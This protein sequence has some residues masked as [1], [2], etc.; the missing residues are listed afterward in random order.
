MKSVGA[1]IEAFT[2]PLPNVNLNLGAVW[3]NTKYRDNLVG[4]NGRPL[5]NALF[6]LPGRRISNSSAWTVTGVVSIACSKAGLAP[7]AMNW[8]DGKTASSA[9]PM[10]N[11]IIGLRPTLSD[12]P[13]KKT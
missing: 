8:N 5:T 4:A 6:Q 7:R 3:V 13:A 11:R 12:N 9:R 2:R 10:P 1:E